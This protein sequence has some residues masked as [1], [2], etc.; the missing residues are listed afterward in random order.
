MP[1][2]NYHSSSIVVPEAIEGS[3]KQA[4][5]NHLSVPTVVEVNSED[6]AT[7]LFRSA[8]VKNANS[9][10]R[11]ASPGEITRAI[12]SIDQRLAEMAAKELKAQIFGFT[13]QNL[14]A[15]HQ[16][17]RELLLA[18][19][20]HFYMASM[21]FPMSVDMSFLKMSQVGTG[22]PTFGVLPMDK[23]TFQMS[24]SKRFQSGYAT[25][26]NPHL[27]T[28]LQPFFADHAKRLAE[29]TS[30]QSTSFISATFA[31]EMPQELTDFIIK[32]YKSKLFKSID[33][34]FEAP[35]W[36]LNV[37]KIPVYQDPLVI[38]R[39]IFENQKPHYTL[40]G[41]FNPTKNELFVAD[42]YSR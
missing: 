41:M 5:T 10:S 24:V 17:E 16:E 33:V 27:Y 2:S 15:L 26:F 36:K 28:D 1:V 12:R 32:S 39:S 31:G 8:G 23:S 29:R 22:Y 40:L 4:L 7:N 34:Y 20:T 38:G 6:L 21:G 11:P 18:T 9:T 3:F 30:D 42:N 37:H 19:K 14:T 25:E 13:F 35:M